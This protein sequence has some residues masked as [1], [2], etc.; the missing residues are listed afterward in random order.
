MGAIMIK[1]R[2]ADGKKANGEGEGSKD[3]TLK[4]MNE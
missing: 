3:W 2:P 4:N 1:E